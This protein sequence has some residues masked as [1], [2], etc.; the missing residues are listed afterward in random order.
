LRFSGW[1]CLSA[2]SR[3]YLGIR[4]PLQQR[5]L[6]CAPSPYSTVCLSR[7]PCWRGASTLSVRQAIYEKVHLR[8]KAQKENGAVYV[9]RK[10]KKA[11][12]AKPATPAYCA[13]VRPP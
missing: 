11:A 6:R 5:K 2:P 13:K 1:P 7:A 10:R 4:A 12:A 9:L 3:K 8:E